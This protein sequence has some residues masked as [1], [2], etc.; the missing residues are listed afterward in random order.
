MEGGEEREWG[1]RRDGRGGDPK[2]WFTPPMSE[3]LKNTLIAE[4]I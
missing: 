3:L 1:I 2:S 4:V